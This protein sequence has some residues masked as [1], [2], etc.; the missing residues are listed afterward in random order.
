MAAQEIA[1]DV[2]IKE[3]TEENELLFEQLH[4][5]QEELEKYYHKL[6]DCEQRKG[7]VTASDMQ[8]GTGT[9]EAA[10]IFAENQK[11]Q[12][13]VEL[14]KTVLRIETQNSLPSRLGNILIAGVGSAKSILS[15]P[16]KLRKLW[17][18]LDRTV[19]PAEL[20]GK[21][22]QKVIEAHGTGGQPAVEKL[23][24]SVFLAS[25][26]RANAYTALARHL[27]PIDVRE[28]AANARLAWETDP[29]PYRLKWLAFR[30]HDADDV[31]NAEALLEMLP[32]DTPMS[33]S[34]QRQAMQIHHESQR[35]RMEEAR[36][37]FEKYQR[38]AEQIAA[39][40]TSLQKLADERQNEVAALTTQLKKQSEEHKQAMERL[41]DRAEELQKTVDQHKREADE[42]RIQQE[43]LQKQALEY[44]SEFDAL[45]VQTA[46]M[47]KNILTQFEP[48]K[49]ELS[50]MM[51]I[52][53][54]A[55][56]N[57]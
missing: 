39:Q 56:V 44:K 6:K 25:P 2:R 46:H 43:Q 34:E 20:G 22:F 28:A 37:R 52:V 5:V 49:A 53:M 31:I 54:G 4:V 14:Q 29:R 26:M 13:I 11:L 40:R 30:L 19:P 1:Q 33:E 50:K 10:A 23:L 38:E 24:D 41:S 21:T 48:D 57:K 42:L 51:R 15:L 55:S 45:A 32:P 47:L 35:K 12:A 36:K 18:A 9:T 17:K 7:M 27:M 16:G 8:T 3:L